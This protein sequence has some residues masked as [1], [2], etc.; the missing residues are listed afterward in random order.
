MLD[1]DW[2]TVGKT[3]LGASIG[4][5]LG[6]ALV[7]GFFSLR[8]E[9]QKRASQATYLAMRLAVLL[10]AFGLACSDVAERNNLNS[11]VEPLLMVELPAARTA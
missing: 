1:F 7:Q 4:S 2:G 6:S 3:L 5:G 10:E 9:R 8:A 11:F